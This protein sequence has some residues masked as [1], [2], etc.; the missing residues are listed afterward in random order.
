MHINQ[1]SDM[2]RP[3]S[4]PAALYSSEKLLFLSFW[5]PFLLVAE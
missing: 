5:F 1:A 4:A 3:T 2:A